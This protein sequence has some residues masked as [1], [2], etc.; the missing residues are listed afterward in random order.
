MMRG[1][2]RRKLKDFAEQQQDNQDQIPM[3]ERLKFRKLN[4]EEDEEKAKREFR[5]KFMDRDKRYNEDN[6]GSNQHLLTQNPPD[7]RPVGIEDQKNK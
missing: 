4:Q 2:F 7:L 1:M 6:Y 5:K 3:V